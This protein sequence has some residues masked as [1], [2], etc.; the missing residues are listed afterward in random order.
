MW[1]GQV[2]TALYRAIPRP[3]EFLGSHWFFSACI[4]LLFTEYHAFG[5]FR[6]VA[7]LG[8]HLTFLCFLSW[9][10]ISFLCCSEYIPLQH[11]HCFLRLCFEVHIIWESGKERCLHVS[12]L[13]DTI[14]FQQNFLDWVNVVQFAC[15]YHYFEMLLTLDMVSSIQT[16]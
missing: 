13:M 14:Y 6:D 15:H 8:A 12:N 11:A 7:F 16:F 1:R 10:R 4:L 3:H 5:I 2:I 9:P